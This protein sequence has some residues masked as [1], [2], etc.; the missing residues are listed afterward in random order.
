MLIVR[1]HEKVD[2]NGSIPFTPSL[3]RGPRST[4]PTTERGRQAL[5]PRQARHDRFGHRRA[6]RSPLPANRSSSLWRGNGLLLSSTGSP[7]SSTFDATAK[8]RGSE[9]TSDYYGLGLFTE[10][11]GAAGRFVGHHGS[12]YPFNA[13]AGRLLDQDMTVVG[14]SNTNPVTAQALFAAPLDLYVHSTEPRDEARLGW[15]AST[16]DGAD[17][18]ASGTVPLLDARLSAR[19]RATA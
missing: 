12:M 14:L 8:P 9:P 18:F 13:F 15:T 7:A 11:F 6:F 10:R 5:V 1:C 19:A 17:P 16:S 3:S 2:P 4:A